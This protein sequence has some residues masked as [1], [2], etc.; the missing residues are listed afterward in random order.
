MPG[1]YCSILS[2]FM[3]SSFFK[4]SIKRHIDGCFALMIDVKQLC[5]PSTE[6]FVVAISCSILISN[7]NY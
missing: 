2:R 7:K 4:A 5:Q 6:L 3:L 1:M